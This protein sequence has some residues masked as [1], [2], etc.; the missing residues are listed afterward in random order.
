MGKIERTLELDERLLQEVEAA[1]LTLEQAIKRGVEATERPI[2]IAAN[3]ERQKQ[4]PAGAE[5][6]ARKW[7]E[8]NAEAIKA[9]NARVERRGM[10]G[11]DL[12]RW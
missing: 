10:F 1:G 2:G 7:A 11:T 12:R 9:Y 8:E 5:A 3:H 6:R 4:D